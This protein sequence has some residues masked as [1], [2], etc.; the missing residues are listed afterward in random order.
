M[1]TTTTRADRIATAHR[2]RDALRRAPGDIPPNSES[3]RGD[4]GRDVDDPRGC[5]MKDESECRTHRGPD[6][7]DPEA[8]AFAGTRLQRLQQLRAARRYRL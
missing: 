4:C 1:N 2:L 3:P 7:S 6:P 5:G 8:L